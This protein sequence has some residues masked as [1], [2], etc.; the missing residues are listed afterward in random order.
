M[1]WAIPEVRLGHVDGNRLARKRRLHRASM[2]DQGNAKISGK[3][4]A[5]ARGQD[6]ERDLRVSQNLCRSANSAITAQ[7]DQHIRTRCNGTPDGLITPVGGFR[8]KPASVCPPEF[9]FFRPQVS[10]I[11]LDESSV[12]LINDGRLQRVRGN[13]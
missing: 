5:G 12:G 11:R 3:E 10:P 7:H 1:L 4:I 8:R 6:G 13:A 2:I 9:L